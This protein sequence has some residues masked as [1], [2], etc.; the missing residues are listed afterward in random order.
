[1]SQVGTQLCGAPSAP[2]LLSSDHTP[3]LSPALN[4]FM[5]A[6]LSFWGMSP[7]IA[8]TVKLASLIFSVS[9]STYGRRGGAGG[10]VGTGQGRVERRDGCKKGQGGGEGGECAGRG[11]GEGLVC[12][13]GWR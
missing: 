3:H 11:G 12:G 9:H 1:M 7:C 8:D 6:S 4:S 13:E 10:G 2:P 5:M